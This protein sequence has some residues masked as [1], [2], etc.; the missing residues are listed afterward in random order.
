MELAIPVHPDEARS[1]DL[2]MEATGASIGVVEAARRGDSNSPGL[3][4]L[5][6][7]PAGTAAEPDTVAVAVIPRR[8]Q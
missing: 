3:S 5:A 1:S 8:A 6:C 2:I 7:R 4:A